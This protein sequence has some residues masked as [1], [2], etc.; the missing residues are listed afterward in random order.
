MVGTAAHLID[1]VP[2]PLPPRKWLLSAPKRLR[3]FLHDDAAPQ[4]VVVRILL[5]AV[6]RF[7]REHS[8]GRRAASRWPSP[9]ASVP[10]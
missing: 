6:E 9:T 5:C 3:R 10:P 4:G 8:P 2:P 1:H 7:L